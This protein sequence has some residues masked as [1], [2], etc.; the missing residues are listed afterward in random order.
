MTIYGY[1][2]KDN[3]TLERIKNFSKLNKQNHLI[4]NSSQIDLPVD[5]VCLNNLL[6][7]TNEI[8]FKDC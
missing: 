3:S 7:Y 6:N 1:S 4:K 8:N 2:F 5:G